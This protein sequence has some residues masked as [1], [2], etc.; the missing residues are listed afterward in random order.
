MAVG[1]GRR[2]NDEG[3]RQLRS[4]V[5]DIV[6]ELIIVDLPPPIFHLMGIISLIDRNLAVVNLAVL[7]RAF[8][9]LLVDRGFKLL[10]V[11]PQE[12]TTLAC[13]ILTLEP[14][15]CIL[16]S[17]NPHIEGCLNDEGVEVWTYSGKE[18]SLKGAGGPACLTRPLLRI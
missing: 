3:I 18:I 2:T 14:R 15:K 7:P 16:L 11:P 8:R 5:A 13:N 4:L 1:R 10:D 12:S 6:D 9:N 17:G